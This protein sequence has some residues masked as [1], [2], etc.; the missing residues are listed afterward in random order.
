MARRS[1]RRAP[2]PP[3]RSRETRAPYS[4]PR[5]RDGG[6]KV[7]HRRGPT[8]GRHGS[9]ARSRTAAAPRRRRRR[10]RRRRMASQ[11]LRQAKALATNGPPPPRTVRPIAAPPLSS[12]STAGSASPSDHPWR[13]TSSRIS[14]SARPSSNV[15]R[16]VHRLAAASAGGGGGGRGD[17]HR[18]SR[19]LLH[20]R[21]RLHE[22]RKLVAPRRHAE[23]GHR[24]EDLLEAHEGPADAVAGRRPRETPE[25]R[26]TAAATATA[27]RGRRCR[28]R[29]RG[30]RCA[31]RR[32]RHPAGALPATRRRG[33]DRGGGGGGPR[34]LASRRLPRQRPRRRRGH[35]AR[36]R[37]RRRRQR[38]ADAVELRITARREVGRRA[39]RAA[40]KQLRT[41]RARRTRPTL[42]ERAADEAL[43]GR[44]VGIG[45]QRRRGDAPRAH[46]REAFRVHFGRRGRRAAGRHSRLG[47]VA[48]L[49]QLTSDVWR[50]DDVIRAG[51]RSPDGLMEFVALLNRLM[52][53]RC[54]T[55]IVRAGARRLA[56][57]LISWPTIVGAAL[58]GAMAASTTS[59]PE[60][61][62]CRILAGRRARRS[63]ACARR[64]APRRAAA[65]H[66]VPAQPPPAGVGDVGHVHR[67]HDPQAGVRCARRRRPQRRF[68]SCAASRASLPPAGPPLQLCCSRAPPPHPPACTLRHRRAGRALRGGRARSRRGRRH[69]LHGLQAR[70]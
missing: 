47:S 21:V 28:R 3:P 1:T 56:N 35:H 53:I 69:G 39:A 15:A 31:R 49:L 26:A 66:A 2:H 18:V 64:A 4:P 17:R 50:R 58:R 34:R 33:G 24:S 11:R 55:Q 62:R 54:R 27:V 51:P 67:E 52:E 41:R 12:S 45:R 6:A 23:L 32:R 16:L 30:R 20:Q 19:R 68:V 60:P 57:E 22:S 42:A 43:P 48:G 13:S 29:V 44:R 40:R 46:E 38:R 37:R 70:V 7:R 65:S 59:K 61:G 9:R 10:R 5:S 8:R 14:A 25:R 36:R 63:A